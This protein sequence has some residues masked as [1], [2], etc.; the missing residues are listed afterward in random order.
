M[1][2]RFCQA[3]HLA[4]LAKSRAPGLAVSHLPSV[5]WW[6]A[7]VCQSLKCH[8]LN[9]EDRLNSLN[10]PRLEF[11]RTRGDMIETYK[12]I[13]GLDFF[14]ISSL[15]TLNVSSGTRGHPYKLIKPSVNTNLYSHFFTNR[16]INNWNNLP[17]NIVTAGTQNTFKNLI[18][19]H[20]N[21]DIYR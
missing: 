9:H 11:R 3:S 4:L 19:K 6:I 18:D 15:F 13:H 2:S 16:V 1:L 20:W 21:H 17:C 10:V 8:N 14:C 7:S 5:A 12:I